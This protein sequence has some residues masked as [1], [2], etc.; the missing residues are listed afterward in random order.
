MRP[1]GDRY[2]AAMVDGV[3]DTVWCVVVAAGSG[4]RF[5]GPK[6]LADLGGSTVLERSVATA[7]AICDGVVVVLAPGEEGEVAGA[8]RVVGGGAS[9]S[10]SVANGLAAVP[11]DVSIVVVHDAARPMASRELFERVIAAVRSGADAAVPVVPVVDTIR[12]T[13]DGTVDRDALRAVQTP[14]GFRAE[15]LRRAHANGGEATDDASLVES[16]GAT[17]V[18]VDGERWNLKITEP[19]DLDVASALVDRA[20]VDGGAAGGDS[21]S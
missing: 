16:T 20:L 19:T 6:H 4:S 2:R 14:Q 3:S 12:H 18:L 1:V 13:R 8:A 10:A 11:D 5:G 17:V 7:S 21:I 15:A 9:R